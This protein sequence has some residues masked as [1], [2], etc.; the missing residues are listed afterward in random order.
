MKGDS[1]DSVF[2]VTAV[3]ILLVFVHFAA[4]GKELGVDLIELF[5]LRRPLTIRQQYIS[6]IILIK[7]AVVLV[8]T[9]NRQEFPIIY[10]NCLHMQIF[11][12][13]LVDLTSMF[14]QLREKVTVQ[15]ALVNR[16][17]SAASCDYLY[18][19]TSFVDRVEQ[20]FF[21]LFDVLDVGLDDLYV[22]LSL[23]NNLQQLGRHL[24]LIRW[25]LTQKLKLA[26]LLWTLSFV[27]LL[28]LLIKIIKY[29]YQ[30]VSFQLV[31]EILCIL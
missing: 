23:I 14:Q 29:F 17:I 27:I 30:V 8:Q 25:H 11:V 18:F 21:D 7:R 24:Q 2:N 1:P 16:L 5:V 13:L 22:V 19:N 20:G 31:G 10:T 15:E 28:V 4:F 3:G 12:G 9:A 6:L 26:L